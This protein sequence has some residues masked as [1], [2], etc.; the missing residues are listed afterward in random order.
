MPAIRAAPLHRTLNASEEHNL[1]IDPEI[2]PVK[3]IR[4]QPYHRSRVMAAQA[5]A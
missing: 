5:Q 2:Q 4:E 3:R 1:K